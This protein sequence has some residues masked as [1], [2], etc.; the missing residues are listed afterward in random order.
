METKPEA[1]ETPEAKIARLEEQLADIKRSQSGVD[2]A[3]NREKK[4]AD[5]LEA[6]IVQG[7]SEAS[8]LS[9]LDKIQQAYAAKE[10]GLELKFYAKAKCLDASIDFALISDIEFRDEPAIERKIAQFAEMVTARSLEELDARLRLS[11]P[12]RAG[13]PSI[14]SKPTALDSIIGKAIGGDLQ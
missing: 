11:T 12:P 2:I 5:A 9:R 10:R 4:R 8:I 3:Y 1:A 6:R 13:N 7:E 14:G